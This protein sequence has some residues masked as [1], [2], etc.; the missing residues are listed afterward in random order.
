MEK[1]RAQLKPFNIRCE[2]CG[3]GREYKGNVI[4]RDDCCVPRALFQLGWIDHYV[5]KAKRYEALAAQRKQAGD[6]DKINPGPP[7]PDPQEVAELTKT[8]AGLKTKLIEAE[9]QQ[10]GAIRQALKAIEEVHGRGQRWQWAAQAASRLAL[11]R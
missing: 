3:E 7:R 2:F 6:G 1:V 9:R 8:S 5:T 4:P 10:P 11:R